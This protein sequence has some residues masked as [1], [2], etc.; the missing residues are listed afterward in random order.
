MC[1]TETL[2]ATIEVVRTSNG[3]TV[4]VSVTNSSPISLTLATAVLTA[5]YWL[6]PPPVDGSP[7]GPGGVLTAVNAADNA[8]GEVAGTLSFYPADGGQL[9]MSWIWPNG[10]GLSA[11]A[12]ANSNS[13]TMTYS[14]YNNLSNDATTLFIV[15]PL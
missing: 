11:V 2:A 1:E 6:K 12:S 7:L 15:T 4:T 13:L 3:K 8:F 14:T 5:G 9:T 10:Q